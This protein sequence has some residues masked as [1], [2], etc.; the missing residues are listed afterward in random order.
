[1]CKVACAALVLIAISCS[2]ARADEDLRCG[3]VIVR[4][5]ESEAEVARKCGPPTTATR[6]E[7]YATIKGRRLHVTLDT[8]TYDFGPSQFVRILGF[9]DA[10]LKTVEL[11]GYGT[12]K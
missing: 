1:M 10:V 9:E 5:G 12:R 7:S 11:G 4:A 2:S 6:R 8:W 3:N